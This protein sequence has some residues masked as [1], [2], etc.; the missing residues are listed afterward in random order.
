MYAWEEARL[1]AQRLLKRY[2]P[3]T[4]PID[5]DAIAHSLGIRVLYGKLPAGTY[6]F[7]V[8]KTNKQ[9]IIGINERLPETQQRFTLAHEVGHFIDRRNAGDSDYSFE[10]GNTTQEDD[11][12]EFYANEFAGALLLPTVALLEKLEMF[13]EDPFAWG[14]IAKHFGVSEKV[15]VKR[16]LRLD[17]DSTPSEPSDKRTRPE[18]SPA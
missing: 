9:A 1:E 16:I 10:D 5:V 6:G 14:L 15:L 11:I 18:T 4:F 3:D 13:N 17:E 12:L 8:K 2:D 7:I